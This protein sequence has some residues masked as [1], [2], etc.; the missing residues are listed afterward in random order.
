MSIAGYEGDDLYL[1][2]SHPLT[3]LNRILH[4][5]ILTPLEDD[6][7]QE[8]EEEDRVKCLHRAHSFSISAGHELIQ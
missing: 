2:L 5:G 8:I 1:V 7:Y 4:C 3:V 6:R